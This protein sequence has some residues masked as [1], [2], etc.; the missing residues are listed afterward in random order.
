MKTL[1]KAAP[2]RIGRPLSFDRD[3]ALHQA[4]LLFWQHGYEATSLS[5][6]TTAMGVTPPSIYTAFGDKKQL[7]LEA[8]K[9]YCSG[10]VTA[11]SIID[12]AENAREA[13]WGLLKNSAIS[14]TGTDTP[15][16]CLLASSTISC[17]AAVADVQAEL[18][19]IRRKIE[20]HL[21]NKIVRDVAAGGMP[22]KTDASALA[23]HAMAVI[24]GMSTLARDGA[25]REKLMRVAQT[26]MLV[27][28]DEN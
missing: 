9:R 14:F 26:A 6:L 19:S 8:V 17:S 15:L 16:G 4:M 18:A 24:Q 23:A 11:K 28:P 25:K 13:A 3:A 1:E 27:W 21:K 2:G 20:I 5:A 10:P 12:E 22:R 7:F